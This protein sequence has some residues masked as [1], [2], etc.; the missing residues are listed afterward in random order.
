[1]GDGRSA[2]RT[3]R[4]YIGL[5]A[6]VG[7]AEE[8]LARGV[9]ALSDLPGATLRGVSCLYATEPWGV[10]DQPEFR[11]AVVALDVRAGR[12]PTSGATDLLIALKDLERAFGRGRRGRWGPREIDLD[13]L[14]FGRA[15]VSTSRPEAG[16]SGDPA[17]ADLP[18]TVPHPL[19]GERLFVLEPLAD[20]APGLVPPGWRETVRTA[21][22]RRRRIDGPSAARPIARWS[23]GAGTWRPLDD[24]GAP[25]SGPADDEAHG[26]GPAEAR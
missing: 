9:R 24:D 13:E 1:M 21:R 17:K 5:G 4:A 7:P 8:T 12:D 23:A 11:N 10:V 19:I 22:D 18:L 2:G 25:T 16:R 6:N 15:R 20:L 14:V 26:P 3:V